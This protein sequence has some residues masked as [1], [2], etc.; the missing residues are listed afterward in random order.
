MICCN[1]ARGGSTELCDLTLMGHDV[2]DDWTVVTVAPAAPVGKFSGNSVTL[3]DVG[4]EEQV[5][6]REITWPLDDSKKQ[7]EQDE[8]ALEDAT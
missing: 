2:V 5:G 4:W 8:D 7:F 6:C 1:G 3:D